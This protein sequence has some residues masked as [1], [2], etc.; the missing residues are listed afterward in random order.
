L[1]SGLDSGSSDWF[2]LLF[3]LWGCKPFQVL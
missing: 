2:I 3:F 1:I